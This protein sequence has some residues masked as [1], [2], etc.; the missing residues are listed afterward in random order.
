MRVGGGSGGCW[1]KLGGM[2]LTVWGVCCP[3]AGSPGALD[4]WTIKGQLKANSLALWLSLTNSEILATL[5]FLTALDFIGG[6]WV[7]IKGVC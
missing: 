7:T 4:S 5:S 3:H 1:G 2:G 6:H